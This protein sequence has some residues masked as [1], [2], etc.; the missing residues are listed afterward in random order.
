MTTP[1]GTAFVPTSASSRGR[2]TSEKKRLPVPNRT[3]KTSSKISSA[4]P[5]SISAGVN[6]ELPQTIRSGPSFA[7]N[8]GS[9]SPAAGDAPAPYIH[10]LHAGKKFPVDR[11]RFSRNARLNSRPEGSKNA[12]TPDF[13]GFLA[14]TFLTSLSGAVVAIDRVGQR[15]TRWLIPLNGVR[16]LPG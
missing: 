5:C 3:G 12:R 11:V 4:S 6:V 13:I 15:D 7:F 1:E 9:R 8:T 16:R 14:F 2:A 10:C